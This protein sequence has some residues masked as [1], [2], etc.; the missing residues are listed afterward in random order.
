LVTSLPMAEKSFVR[1]NRGTF[2]PNPDANLLKQINRGFPDAWWNHY[3]E[4]IRKREESR[5]SPEEHLEL[6]RLTDQLERREAKRLQALVK[7]A[8][9]RRQPLASLMQDLGLPGKADV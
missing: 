6:I 8:E 7:L 4:L 3:H 1:G 9:L 5:L 2:L